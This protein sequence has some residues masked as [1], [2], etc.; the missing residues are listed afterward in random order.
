MRRAAL[1]MIFCK[2]AS[3][4]SVSVSVSVEVID[5]YKNITF[6]D[7]NRVCLYKEKISHLRR[8]ENV[9]KKYIYI[10]KKIHITDLKSVFQISNLH[11]TTGYQVKSGPYTVMHFWP[12]MYLQFHLIRWHS[13]Q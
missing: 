7:L 10:C 3:Q 6:P 5:G 9:Y 8:K 13:C 11:V 1:A 2:T 4:V 12:Y